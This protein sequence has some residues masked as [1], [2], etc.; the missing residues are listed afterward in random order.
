M[1]IQSAFNSGV[2]G[3]NKATDL[4]SESANNIA[5]QQVT[6]PQ[7]E[8]ATEVQQAAPQA[9]PIEESLINLR[10]AENQARNSVNIIETADEVVGSLIDTRV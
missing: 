6:K 2:A 8:D 10:V 1:N 4:A 5:Q 9:Q 3:F 7:T